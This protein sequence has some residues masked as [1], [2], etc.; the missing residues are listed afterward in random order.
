ML[1]LEWQLDPV[2]EVAV[3][4]GPIE[5]LSVVV[6]KSIVARRGTFALVASIFFKVKH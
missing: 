2:V 4:L 1:W 6:N 3:E 5:R